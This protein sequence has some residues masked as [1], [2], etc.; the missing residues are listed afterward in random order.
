MEQRRLLPAH[1]NILQNSLLKK[2][3]TEVLLIILKRKQFQVKPNRHEN[4]LD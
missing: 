1:T 2:F 4:L 3:Q